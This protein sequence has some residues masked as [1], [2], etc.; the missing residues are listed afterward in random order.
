MEVVMTPIHKARTGTVLALTVAL[1]GLAA[2]GHSTAP[3]PGTAP[4][5]PPVTHPVTTAPAAPPSTAPAAAPTPPAASTASETVIFSRISYPWHWPN[6]VNRPGSISHAYPVPPV[7]K[8][9]DI[10]AGDH[11]SDPGE[12]PYNRLSFTFTTAF[13]S[14]QF[15]FV[16]ALVG[17]PGG[18]IVPLGGNGV[19]EVT[20]RQAQAHT[21]KGS[22][23]VVSQPPRH[24]G[25]T[26]MVDWAQGGDFEGVLTYGIGIAAPVPHS[27]PQFPV[28]TIE[29]EKVNAQGQH[30][31][32]VAI[33][34]S[35]STS[36]R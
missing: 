15:R 32:I 36:A 21:A 20:F 22:S 31:Y 23:S 28:R 24:L 5:G 1:A 11:R 33:D 27:N 3:P 26:R 4:P 29:V 8:L 34:I 13:P 25:Y 10:R 12:Q 35:A 30:L 9:I 19:L 6:D 18:R 14:Y 16:N 17:D 2:C 7:P